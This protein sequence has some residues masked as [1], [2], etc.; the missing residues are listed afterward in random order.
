[1]N[2]SNTFRARTIANTSLRQDNWVLRKNLK[3]LIQTTKRNMDIQNRIDEL[4][5][6][7]LQCK[8]IVSLV[9]TVAAEL[10]ERFGLNVVTVCLSEEFREIAGMISVPDDPRNRT[11]G[12]GAGNGGP[13]RTTIGNMLFFMDK[14]RLRANFKGGIE[15]ILQ[16][17][18]DYGSVDFFGIRHFKRVRSEAIIPLFHEEQ[19]LG[20]LNLGSN[21]PIRYKEGTATDYLKRFAWILSL[22]LALQKM[23]LRLVPQQQE[24]MG[25]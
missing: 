24:A 5:E 12:K 22:A 2:R 7:I 16:E 3:H 17:R 11:N 21:N 8:D 19:F 1:M 25:E 10:K 4:G 23:K 6:I 14:D 13:T 18:L 20:S 9:E 15:P